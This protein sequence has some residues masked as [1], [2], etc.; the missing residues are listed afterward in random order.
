[1]SIR[2]LV[3]RTAMV[4]AATTMLSGVIAG[5][6]ASPA[7]AST[8]GP[9]M[10]QVCAQGEYPAFV[11]VLSEPVPNSDR[12]TSDFSSFVVSPGVSLA[13]GPAGCT[14]FADDTSGAWVQ[15]DV[16]GFRP[17]GSQ[18]WVNDTWYNSSVS[19]LGIG[20]RE[21]PHIIGSR[22]GSPSRILSAR[23]TVIAI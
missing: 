15:V 4:L 1:M 17:D 22:P 19:G 18:F 13:G 6:V 21:P 10:L 11:H 23:R 20:A 2:K 12:T 7:S 5:A 8:I 9:G 3:A 16:V 14:W